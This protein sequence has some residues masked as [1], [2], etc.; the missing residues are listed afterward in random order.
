[1]RARLRLA[2]CIDE[3]VRSRSISNDFHFRRA[4]YFMCNMFETFLDL[5]A[6][7]EGEPSKVRA[8]FDDPE[9]EILSE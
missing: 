8:L 2:L 3:G 4:P 9:K 6:A 1:M 5:Q 7:S